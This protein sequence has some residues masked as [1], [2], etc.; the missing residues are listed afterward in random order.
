MTDVQSV[1][2][3]QNIDGAT[4][5]MTEEEMKRRT[6]E[7]QTTILGSM[8]PILRPELKR[9]VFMLVTFVLITFMY[10]FLRLFKENVVVS[11]LEINSSNYLKLFTFRGSLLVVGIIQKLLV[12]YDINKAFEIVIATFGTLLLIVAPFIRFRESIQKSDL[13]AENFF[14]ANNA[15]ARGIGFLW[16]LFLISNHWL[17]AF[18]YVLAEVIG[19]IMVSYMFLTYGNFNCNENQNRRFV[20]IFYIGSNLAAFFATKVYNVWN[21]WAKEQQVEK[22]DKWYVYFTLMCVVLFV[23]IFILKRCLDN[24]FKTQIVIAAPKVV[25]KSGKAKVSVSDGVYYAIVSRLLRNMCIT[26]LFYNISSNLC[27]SV[28]KNA[29]TAYAT[30]NNL[31]V[32]NF[33]TGQKSSEMGL[34]SLIVVAC[35][36][37]PISRLY[38]IFGVFAAGMVPMLISLFGAI[39]QTYC[40]LINYSALGDNNMSM[41]SF[42]ED[43]VR[44]MKLEAYGNLYLISAIKVSKYA[45]FDI[46]KEAISMKISPEIRPLFKG[47]YDGVCGKFGKCVGSVYNIIVV[48][49]LKKSDCRYFQPITGTVLLVFCLFWAYAVYYLSKSFNK[50]S[51]EN[52][53]MSPD[54]IEGFKFKD[55]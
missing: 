13:W 18:F 44:K 39:F 32:R 3:T 21:K 38:E 25:K 7:L 34:T 6:D 30:Y 1:Q 19:S 11:V 36:L 10:T 9:F 5:I 37:S 26:T 54:Y 4:N 24:I 50:A 48:G 31:D 15:D 28:F 17:L 53:Y 2:N 41:F 29:S 55:E 23:L 27:E 22:V 8:F 35:M 14:I 42:F 40:A 45:F 47:V 33:S 12:H 52:T 46:V 20:R 16:G 51:K 43:S 49:I